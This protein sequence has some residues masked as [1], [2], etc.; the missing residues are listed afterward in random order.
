MK[1][2]GVIAIW[3]LTCSCV[4]TVLYII[5]KRRAG[6]NGQRIPERTLLIWSA[7]GGWPGAYFTG[8]K[9]RHKTQKLSFRIYFA[10]AV[11]VNS[12]VIALIV[13]ML[14]LR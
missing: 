1:T 11:A 8:H 5:D 2:L 14:L 9:I 7:L 4:A 13:W 6:Q 12:L 10:L 3:M